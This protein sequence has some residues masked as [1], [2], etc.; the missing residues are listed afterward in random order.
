MLAKKYLKSFAGALKVDS[1]SFPEPY[2]W[3]NDDDYL[4]QELYY[5]K[6]EKL[7]D[8]LGKT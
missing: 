4:T 5:Q 7:L 3:F 1:K 6:I 2:H 8:L